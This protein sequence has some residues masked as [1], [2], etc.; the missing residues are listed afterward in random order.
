VETRIV[1]INGAPG[2][3]SHLNRE[4]SFVFTMDTNEQYIHAIYFITNPDKI[5]H[6][7]D[8]LQAETSGQDK[9]R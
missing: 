7:P 9:N 2:V 1:L 4:P 5:K 3:V 6:I 8:L